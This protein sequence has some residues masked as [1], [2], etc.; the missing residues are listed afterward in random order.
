MKKLRLLTAALA[1][2]G[3]SLAITPQA[4]AHWERCATAEGYQF[5]STY[6]VFH[7]CAGNDG[8]I[9]RWRISP[10]NWRPAVWRLFVTSFPT[11]SNGG[12]DRIPRRC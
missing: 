7:L 2:A 10:V 12:R 3:S 8:S 9:S 6:D 5:A 4:G 11:C 1:V